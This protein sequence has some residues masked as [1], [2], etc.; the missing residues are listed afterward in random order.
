MLTKKGYLQTTGSLYKTHYERPRRES[1]WRL[2][3]GSS[4]TEYTLRSLDVNTP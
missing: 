3:Q 1:Q 4:R 2:V